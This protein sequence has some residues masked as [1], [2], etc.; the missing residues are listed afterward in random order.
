M[1]SK[2][3][4]LMSSRNNATFEEVKYGFR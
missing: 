2:R 4:H 3:L 1:Y